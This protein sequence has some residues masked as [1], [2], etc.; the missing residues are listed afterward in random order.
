MT[1]AGL[2]RQGQWGGGSGPGP[3]WPW[4][5]VRSARNSGSA[6]ATA[7]SRVNEHLCRG[8]G[9][10]VQRPALGWRDRQVEGVTGEPVGVPGGV[11]LGPRCQLFLPSA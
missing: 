1:E 10:R 2:S 7:L 9:S 5:G 8:V 11:A 3:T 6:S 4:T